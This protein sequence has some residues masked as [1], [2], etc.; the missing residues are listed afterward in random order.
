MV[1]YPYTYGDD[2]PEFTTKFTLSRVLLIALIIS[3]SALTLPGA[4]LALNS[5]EVL[6]KIEAM[7]IANETTL[8]A[9]QT[10]GPVSAAACVVSGI[11]VHNAYLNIKAGKSA[12]AT[13]YACGAA[14]LLCTQ[15]A[16]TCKG[17]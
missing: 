10:G 7:L 13:A 11:C 1:S 6:D 12:G 5:T 17:L 8:K 2:G 4:A 3:G 15:Y 16:A 14:A 9:K